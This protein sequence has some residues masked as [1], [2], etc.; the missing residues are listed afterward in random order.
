MTV[1][2]TGK[3]GSTGARPLASGTSVDEVQDLIR[4]TEEMLD[5]LKELGDT[6]Y[7]RLRHKLNEN[8]NVVREKLTDRVERAENGSDA[9]GHSAMRLAVTTLS[10]ATLTGFVIGLAV[11]RLCASD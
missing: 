2:A 6:S 4:R 10:V 9:G 3:A 11:A 8:V 1:V 5:T 7:G